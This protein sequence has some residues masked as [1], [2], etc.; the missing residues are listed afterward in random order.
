MDLLDERCA[1]TAT[2]FR[3][4]FK[5]TLAT[6]PKSRT[7]LSITN[8][9]ASCD[10]VAFDRRTFKW[11]ISTKITEIKD[12]SYSFLILGQWAFSALF[13]QQQC[14]FE[15]ASDEFC[16]I[17]LADE[18]FECFRNALF[19]SLYRARRFA[20]TENVDG[21]FHGDLGVDLRVGELALISLYRF[22]ETSIKTEHTTENE[23][24]IYTIIKC[25]VSFCSNDSAPT[26]SSIRS[27]IN[28][29]TTD[30]LVKVHKAAA[31]SLSIT[32]RYTSNQRNKHYAIA[33]KR[34]THHHLCCVHA[35]TQTL[36]LSGL[37]LHLALQVAHLRRQQVILFLQLKHLSLDSKHHG[38][39]DYT[40][41]L[42]QILKE[43]SKLWKCNLTKKTYTL[44]DVFT[45]R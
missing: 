25:R 32:S 6:T 31:N 26:F 17:W 13:L 33:R 28:W 7:M 27:T 37:H 22:E 20:L 29:P 4:L 21:A 2:D 45:F 12:N 24:K 18:V 3:F 5:G 11:M 23:K 9:A 16:R 15:F 36:D 43:I 14:V 39:V 34:T 1:R 35:L 8:S 41:K 40:R 42:H 38:V 44:G 10:N 30:K 19:G